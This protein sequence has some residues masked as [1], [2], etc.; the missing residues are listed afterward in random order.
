MKFTDR[1][2]QNWRIA[3]VRK[4]IAPGAR[5]LDIGCGFGLFAAYFGQTQPKRSIVGIDPD[6]R[7]IKMAERVADSLGLAQ[8]TFLAKDARELSVDRALG[9]EL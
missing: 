7:R 2:L 3:K 1:F 5:I 6:A 9:R 4:F 8:H